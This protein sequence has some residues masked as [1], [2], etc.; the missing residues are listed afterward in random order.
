MPAKTNNNHSLNAP[1]SLFKPTYPSSN[2]SLSTYNSQS[3]SLNAFAT[4]YNIPTTTTN[5]KKRKR[6]NPKQDPPTIH[7]PIHHYDRIRL[8]KTMF[9]IPIRRR[10]TR[11]LVLF[12]Q[13]QRHR[14][15]KYNGYSKESILK[16]LKL[17][18]EMLSIT[19]IG[20]HNLTES[21]YKLCDSERVI[22]PLEELIL[23]LG[24]DFI[25]K[26]PDI[27]NTELYKFFVD[28]SYRLRKLYTNKVLGKPPSARITKLFLSGK[29][30]E[31]NDNHSSSIAL[32]NYLKALYLKL[33]PPNKPPTHLTFYTNKRLSNEQYTINY[34]NIKR[35]IHEAC[36][37]QYNYNSNISNNID[38]TDSTSL[39]QP[40][41]TLRNS[42]KSVNHRINEFDKQGH[43]FKSRNPHSHMLMTNNANPSLF[44]TTETDDIKS[45]NLLKRIKIIVKTLVE[46]KSIVINNT[47]KNLGLAIMPTQWYLDQV[48]SHLLDP[49]NYVR[50]EVIP[51]SVEVFEKLIKQLKK[52]K[53]FS[54]YKSQLAQYIFSLDPRC[55]RT[56]A[57]NADVPF[58]TFY[59]LAKVHKIPIGSRPIVASMGSATYNASKYVDFILQPVMRSFNSILLNSLELNRHL[60]CSKFPP[61]TV[62]WSSDVSALYPSIDIEDGIKALE[63]ILRVYNG[64]M[65]DETQRINSPLIITLTHWILTNNYIAFGT[66]HWQQIS[67]TAMGTPM[68]VVFANLYL[69][70]LEIE[71]LEIL[72]PHPDFKAP[73]VYCRFVDD[74]FQANDSE[75]AGD[76]FFNTLGTRRPRIKL[77]TKKGPAVDYLDS[78]Y[79]T[80]V[81]DDLSH[82]IIYTEL[83]QKPSNQYLYIPLFSHHQP[84]V[85]KAFIY[86]ELQ[87]YKM[88]CYKDATFQDTKTKFS[89]RL[90]VRGYP[91][92]FIMTIYSMPIKTRIELLFPSHTHTHYNI[93]SPEVPPIR[94]FNTV[95]SP[96]RKT[97]DDNNQET[98]QLVLFKITHTPRFSNRELGELLKFDDFQEQFATD[99]YPEALA[100]FSTRP[101]ISLLR[102]DKIQDQL[103]RSKFGHDLPDD[104]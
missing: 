64:K 69:L 84:A 39:R 37:F 104:F 19:N 49:L 102:T 57:M 85:F 75:V 72:K 28:Y 97:L 62:L 7:K 17:P 58:S 53:Q 77:E 83:Y 94:H 35:Y 43:Y 1:D 82:C 31:P 54:N 6:H 2:I 71:T 15:P 98:E 55:D 46:D 74:L 60:E 99:Q 50:L 67:G 90:K 52:I 34:V 14:Q 40:K 41:I 73:L 18:E 93:T 23:S 101:T 79:K 4:T 68:A 33:F 8:Q 92:D 20:L 81:A 87:R 63:Y 11:D 3:S 5:N 12:K 32:E 30:F 78:T 26:P 13:E 29:T 65:T 47:D 10:R 16:Q 38:N 86:A 42:T 21:K 89:N 100:Q 24:P 48:H 45:N 80:E 22:T 51:T 44:Y 59:L 91:N 56:L 95:F 88:I 96:L 76:L 66:S 9:K 61:S 25:P 27:N 103:I 36:H 70:V